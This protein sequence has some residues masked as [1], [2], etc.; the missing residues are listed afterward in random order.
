MPSFS[1]VPCSRSEPSAAACSRSSPGESFNNATARLG[2]DLRDSAGAPE[3]RPESPGAWLTGSSASSPER[4]G[5]GRRHAPHVRIKVWRTGRGDKVRGYGLQ[6]AQGQG[7]AGLPGARWRDGGEGGR[8]GAQGH[9][10]RRGFSH[11][12]GQAR[13]R[14]TQNTRSGARPCLE[15]SVSP[16]VPSE[17]AAGG[18]GR[19]TRKAACLAGREAAR[20]LVADLATAVRSCRGHGRCPLRLGRP[21]P[22]SPGLGAGSSDGSRAPLG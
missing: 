12:Q 9:P 21:T 6:Q 10:S 8:P 22:A 13:R 18:T 20:R 17:R 2:Q 15:R 16:D 11:G 4:A 3:A 19:A 14:S 1:S 5:A 7:A